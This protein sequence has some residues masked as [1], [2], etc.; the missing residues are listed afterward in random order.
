MIANSIINSFISGDYST[1]AFIGSKEDW[2]TYASLG[3]LGTHESSFNKLEQFNNPEVQFYRGA[4]Y[5]LNGQDDLAVKTLQ[6][7]DSEY[8][9]NLLNLITKREIKILAQLP[10]AR[11][12]SSD[13]INILHP[14]PKFKVKNI[15]FHPNDYPNQP[16]ADALSFIDNDFIPDFYI[17]KMVEWHLIPPNLQ[18]LPCPIFGH[19][20]DYDL[21]IQAI[22]PWLQIFDELLVSDHTEHKGLSSLVRIPVSTFPKSFGVPDKLPE[23]DEG[24]RKIDFFQSGSLLHPYHHDKMQPF[25]ETLSSDNSNILIICDG[26]LYPQDYYLLLSKSKSTFTFIRHSGGIPTRSLETLAMG[27]AVVVQ[28]ESILT[29]FYGE[30]DG[31]FTYEPNCG[32]LKSVI[33]YISKNWGDV[34]KSAKKGMQKVRKDFALSKVASQ[35]FRFLTFLAAKPR[36]KRKEIPFSYLKQKRTVL[37]KGWLPGR[38]DAMQRIFNANMK[39]WVDRDRKEFTYSDYIDYGREVVLE[40]ADRVERK[41]GIKM[42][43]GN[44]N[45]LIIKALQI[46]EEGKFR[47]P[48]SLPIIFNMVRTAFHFGTPTDVNKS[49][50]LSKWVLNQPVESFHC[51]PFEDVFPWDFNSAFFNY[52][53]YF[54]KVNDWIST[55]HNL[56]K[57]LVRI[58]YASIHNYLSYY[59]ES[60]ENARLA[61]ELDPDFDLYKYRLAQVIINNRDE[62]HYNLAYH[63]LNG[64]S[65]SSFLFVEAFTLLSQMKSFANEFGQPENKGEIFLQKYINAQKFFRDLN[66]PIRFSK[67]KKIHLQK[68]IEPSNDN[69]DS[70]KNSINATG[71]NCTEISNPDNQKQLSILIPTMDRPDF[72]NR[73]LRYYRKIGFKGTII[74]GDSSDKINREKNSSF[75]QENI[76]QLNIIYEYFDNPPYL[77]DGMCMHAMVALCRTPYVVYSGDDDFLIPGGLSHCIG[78]LEREK[79][80]SAAFG[81][82]INIKLDL[83][84]AWGTPV[85]GQPWIGPDFMEDLPNQRLSKYL[86]NGLSTQ[87]FVHRV[88]V[89][90]RMYEH[91]MQ[92]PSRYLGPELL[93]CCFSTLLGKIKRLDTPTLVF[94]KNPDQIFSWEKTSLFDLI[95]D[96]KW[97]PS[98]IT[99]IN[100]V[101]EQLACLE[102]VDKKVAKD[103][104]TKELWAHI[105]GVLMS[106]Y[107]QR[108]LQNDVSDSAS[109]PS[110]NTLMQNTGIS[111]VLHPILSILTPN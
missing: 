87:Y 45:E 51:Y 62:N 47:Y 32:S 66:I 77:H 3:I 81:T 102:N 34:Q 9:K 99:I 27:S 79:E 20:A 82:R 104:V 65:T 93:P 55:K 6:N 71:F 17:C 7:I 110:L 43:S 103:I 64:L 68:N 108:Y 101:S 107:K 33:N 53:T 28:K 63:L 13:F 31:V 67:W 76:H 90:K 36:E 111:K 96:A 75:V 85:E 98:I 26:F 38:Q 84:G 30:D 12:G 41:G 39:Y 21:H 49:I 109:M 2:R 73:T 42:L 54:D 19:S 24:E 105:T 10:W 35:Y 11:Y 60:Y 52:R 100:R 89:W 4:I 18:A 74:I 40:Y 37:S 23:I 57:D 86:R 15:S 44:D 70:A 69:K 16:Y 91:V 92:V 95:N 46:F 72:I 5:W 1:V 58:I 25:F 80:L 106:Q 83:A 59:E 78:I 97:S 29:L 88:D 56:S 48:K 50:S 8:A 61:V 94:Q 22:F 14:D